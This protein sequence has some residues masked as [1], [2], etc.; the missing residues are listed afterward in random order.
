MGIVLFVMDGP[1]NVLKEQSISSVCLYHLSF[2]GICMGCAMNRLT[3]LFNVKSM[4]YVFLIQQG[5][6]S[7]T[8]FRNIHCHS[9]IDYCM[10]N[11]PYRPI[12]P[13]LIGTTQQL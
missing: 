2:K 8:P 11:Y 9:Y 4:S 6:H 3:T 12:R 5:L 1:Y 7:L 13:I 10:E